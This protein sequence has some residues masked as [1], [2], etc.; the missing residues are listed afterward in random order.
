MVAAHEPQTPGRKKPARA[1]D[2][3]QEILSGHDGMAAAIAAH[4]LGQESS[5][6]RVSVRNAF[7]LHQKNAPRAVS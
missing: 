3:L 2:R 5:I 6:G 4:L 7:R 1:V